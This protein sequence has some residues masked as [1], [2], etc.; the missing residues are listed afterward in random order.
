MTRYHGTTP[1]LVKARG[2]TAS[3][4]S[5][6]FAGSKVFYDITRPTEIAATESEGPVITVIGKTGSITGVP[7]GATVEAYS[8]DGRAVARVCGSCD[9]TSV[10]FPGASVYVIRIDGRSYKVLVR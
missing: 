5:M 2:R 6:L 9:R 4:R 7:E 8:T 3:I 1:S 10:A